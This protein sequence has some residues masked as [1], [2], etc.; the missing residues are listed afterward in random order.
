MNK[1]E[2]IKGIDLTIT[3]LNTIKESLVDEGTDSIVATATTPKKGV[4]KETTKAVEEPVEETEAKEV[5]TDNFDVEEL[6]AM[7]YNEFKTFASNLGVKC[8][9]TRDEI[10]ERILALNIEAEVE[11][12][13]E[14]EAT[15]SDTPK[16][17]KKFSKAKADE[18]TTDEFD[19]QAEE[20]AKETNVEDIISALADVNIKA[21]KKNAVDKLADALRKGLIELDDE[22]VNEDLEAQGDDEE[23]EEITAETYFVEFDP[24]GYNDPDNMSEERAEAV[25]ALV[26]GVLE[27][28]ESGQISEDDILS[29]LQDNTTDDEKDLL[30]DDHTEEQLI[31]FYLEMI[32]RTVDDEGEKH[33][34]ADPFELNGSDVCCG[35]ELKYV[36]KTGKYV[37]EICGT[38]YEAEE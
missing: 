3:G 30:S 38:E 4:K 7:K 15:K 27:Q 5:V 36:K 34:P 6:K 1:A 26:T 11:P 25:I 8:T 22:E 19:K 33:E 20:I 17:G 13:E 18:P 31:G 14:K 28:I 37:C 12:V 21:T 32:K 24:D 9:G 2:L 29:Y 10:M 23:G 16:S 35:H